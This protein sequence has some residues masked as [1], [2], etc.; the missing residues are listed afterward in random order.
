VIENIVQ[1]SD[2]VWE[3]VNIPNRG[4]IPNLPEDAIIECPGLLNARGATGIHVGP[5]PEG[6]AE[7][8]R[9]EITVSHLTVDAVVEG[10]RQLALQALLLDPVIRDLDTGKKVL[11]DYLSAYREYLPSFW[12]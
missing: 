4:Q 6:I 7:L 10:D 5:M 8:L 3:A 2:F 11:D 1:D 12:A 9:R